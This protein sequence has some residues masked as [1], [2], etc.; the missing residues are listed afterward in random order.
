MTP[1]DSA[2]AALQ[3]GR[4]A[5]AERLCRIALERDPQSPDGLHLLGVISNRFGRREEAVA[6]IERAVALQPVN[7]LFLNNLGNALSDVGQIEKALQCYGRA[8]DLLPGF[9]EAR[10]NLVNALLKRGSALIGEQRLED[11]E[12]SFRQALALDATNVRACVNLADILRD[13]GRL[14]QSE[15][16]ARRAIELKPDMAEA[17]LS[18]ANA[19]MYSGRLAEAERHCRRALALNGSL[20]QGHFVLGNL[21]TFLGRV[22]EGVKSY[23]QALSLRPSYSVAHSNL[24]FA[25]DMLEGVTVQEQQAERA[26]WYK[27]HAAQHVRPLPYRNG[28]EPERRLRI[29]YVSADFCRHSAYYIF[30][31]VIRRHDPGSFEVFCYS[32]VRAGDDATESLKKSVHRWR[33]CAAISDDA[34]A[35]QIRDD[36]I[37][38]LVDLSGHS[39]GNRLM[40]FARKPAPVQV[41]AWGH[42]TGTGIPQIDYL[43]ADPVLI[44]KSDRR[45]YAERVVDLSCWA[46]YEPPE[47]FP[48]GPTQERPRCVGL[49]FGCMNRIEKLSPRT[50]DLWGRILAA[51]PGA[52]LLIK[53]QALDDGGLKANLIGR[54]TAIGI[55]PTRLILRGSSPHVEHLGVYAEIDVALDPFPQNGGVSTA[56]ALWMGVPVVAL[57]GSTVPSRVSAAYLAAAGMKDWIGR[58]E[59]NYVAIAVTAARDARS[60]GRMRKSLRRELRK[61][62]LGRPEVYA[63]EVEKAYRLMW[64]RWCRR[65]AR[66]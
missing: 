10:S 5:D 40:V 23:R 22:A 30:A 49:T 60:L 31:P 6:L 38:I 33:N 43:L 4:L 3:A 48:D 25:L 51:V 64:Q 59:E 65:A 54:F 32:G 57:A 61:T 1:L 41:T 36:S 58:D 15:A 62:V 29:G 8:I 35:Q 21:F 9:V 46:C 50:I 18:L 2:V 20:P 47:Y 27:Q 56:E 42:A 52:R 53:G 19:L 66:P 28:R 55:E 7:P 26:R 45:Y 63:R 37:D 44:P 17:H 12:K 16:A 13:L 24:I 34:L 39:V 11:A 14:K